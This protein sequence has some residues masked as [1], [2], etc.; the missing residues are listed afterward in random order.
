MVGSDFSPTKLFP[1]ATTLER[2]GRLD[3]L[4]NNAGVLGRQ[5]RGAKSIAALDIDEFAHVLRV[6]ALGKIIL[7]RFTGAG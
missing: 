7:W 2:H 3:V 1:V 5:A 6:N 4:C